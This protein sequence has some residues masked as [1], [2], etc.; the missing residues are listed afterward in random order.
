MNMPDDSQK[1]VSLPGGS[2]RRNLFRWLTVIIIFPILGLLAW[3]PAVFSPFIYD[4]NYLVKSARFNTPGSLIHGLFHYNR[5]LVWLLDTTS[6]HLWGL[7]P[8]GYHLVNIALHVANALLLMGLF[9]LLYRRFRQT[10]PSP[11]LAGIVGLFFLLNGSLSMA[12]VLIS[13]RSVLLVTFFYLLALILFVRSQDSDGRF[14]WLGVATAYLAAL[15]SKEIAITLPAALFLVAL[16]DGQSSV[17]HLW[18]RHRKLAILGGVITIGFLIKLSHF[19]Y[20]STVGSSQLPFNRWEYLLTE[21]TAWLHYLKI[22]LWPNPA[23]MSGD[24][25]WPVIRSPFEPHFLLALVIVLAVLAGLILAWT[26]QQRVLAIGGLFFFLSLAPTS[27]LVPIADPVMEY[28]LYLPAIGLTLAI[29]MLVCLGVRKLA[30]A[31]QHWR[32]AIQISLLLLLGVCLILSLRARLEA[33]RSPEAFWQ[34]AALKSPDKI[35]P[36]FNLAQTYTIRGQ[37]TKAL[38]QGQKALA[39][40]PDASRV[41]SLIGDIYREKGDYAKALEFYKRS[42]SRDSQNYDVV[43][44]ICHLLLE[45]GHYPEA[46]HYLSRFTGSMKDDGYYMNLATYL[47][48][49]GQPERAIAIYRFLLDRSPELFAAW[50]NLGG[51]YAQQGDVAG[52]EACYR[53]S[54]HFNPRYYLA[55]YGLGS[56]FLQTKQMD[57]A[58]DNLTQAR[59]LN[60]SFPWTYYQLGNF[61][62]MLRNYAAAEDNFAVFL[63]SQ[64][65]HA[66]AWYRQGLVK[67]ELHE[68][69][70]ARSCFRQALAL[71]PDWDPPRKAL[72]DLG[73]NH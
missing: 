53:R 66:E 34:D 2:G 72:A 49:T 47:N 32:T 59:D 22:Y 30:D 37:W 64:P 8:L 58:L 33:Y 9:I 56:L 62:A 69:A 7:N 71:R 29:G 63:K 73:E 21:V 28:R 15:L 16:A 31:R 51:I 4:D 38:R 12:V 52:A 19:N 67:E 44:K 70:A 68:P 17:R 46:W 1:N 13:A 36:H 48:K 14:I 65:D 26:R 42:L 55:Y 23:W 5:P 20:G 25:A 57:E 10:D 18:Q 45:T 41:L 54:L 43:N 3:Y 40:E 11:L 39:L 35:R 61:F 27:S 24:W 6:F 50:S 60:P